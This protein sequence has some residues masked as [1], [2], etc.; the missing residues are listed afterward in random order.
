MAVRVVIADAH[1]VL[2]MG[3]RLALEGA[4]RVVGETGESTAV[5]ALVQARAPDVLVLGVDL[6]G[7]DGVAV[8]EA[9]Q[10]AGLPVRILVFSTYAAPLLIQAMVQAGVAGY[11]TKDE[12]AQRLQ[13]AVLGIARGEDG[14]F[15][16]AVASCLGD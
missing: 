10:A 16:P 14:W 9:I 2:R 11:L 12:P 15:S 5:V 1:P 7:Q 6:Q 8:A 13:A 4:V 3:M